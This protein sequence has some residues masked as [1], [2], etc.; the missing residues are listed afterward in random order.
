VIAA[1][2]SKVIYVGNG[3]GTTFGFSMPLPTGSTGSELQLTVID[4]LGNVTLLTGNFSVNVAAGTVS[5]PTI[6]GVAPLGVGVNALP[7]GWT[8]VIARVLPLAQL[9]SILTQGIFDGPS[10]MAA[11]DNIVMMIQQLQEQ[12]NRATLVAINQPSPATIPFAPAVTPVGVV[13]INGTWAQIQA[14]AA[15]APTSQF[16]AL[17]TSGDQAG[18][19]F[20]Y[21]GNTAYGNG[22]FVSIG[23]G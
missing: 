20:F 5:Y 21:T 1:S 15:A 2:P 23:G 18:A 4:N 12:I 14:Y 9:L 10:F 8:L 22:G 13:Q 7:V 3:V 6:G 11:L 16:Y 19:Q 17:V